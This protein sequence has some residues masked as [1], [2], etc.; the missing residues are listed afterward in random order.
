MFVGRRDDLARLSMTKR[1]FGIMAIV[2][3][4]AFI[5]GR[6]FLKD[7]IKPA[8]EKNALLR[9]WLFDETGSIRFVPDK[10]IR[11]AN[12]P[13]MKQSYLLDHGIRVDYYPGSTLTEADTA[14]WTGA[15]IVVMD[16]G[17]AVWLEDPAGKGSGQYWIMPVPIDRGAA[18]MPPRDAAQKGMPRRAVYEYLKTNFELAPGRRM[19]FVLAEATRKMVTE[20]LGTAYAAFVFCAALFAMVTVSGVTVLFFGFMQLVL[21]AFGG[22][23]LSLRQIAVVLIYIFFYHRIFA[24]TFDEGFARATG[25]PVEAYNLLI[26]VVVAVIIVLAMNLVG[27]LL[28]SA[29]V[30]FPA[31]SA[32]RVYKRFL[33][34]TIC[35]AVLSVVC[36]LSGM[37]IAILSGTPVGSTIVAIDILAF[38]IFSLIGALAGKIQK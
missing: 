36:A 38:L 5:A 28:I 22:P 14:A 3:M 15:G 33:S 34:V 9:K 6:F 35:A 26:A 32:M 19:Q 10:G 20:Y 13:E 31:L 24:V 30:I 25:Q 1:P 4:A 11:T 23:A 8:I 27:S 16:K 17:M 21:S 29:L 12:R 37:L 7:S 2:A 18:V